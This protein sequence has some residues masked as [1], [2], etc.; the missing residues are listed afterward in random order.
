MI[1]LYLIECIKSI[2]HIAIEF[3][4]KFIYVIE[5]E[6]WIKDPPKHIDCLNPIQS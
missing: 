2:I 3:N 5:N 4:L 1:K 6:L